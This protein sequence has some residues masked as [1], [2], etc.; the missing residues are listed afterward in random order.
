MAFKGESRNRGGIPGGRMVLTFIEGG[1]GI[2]QVEI[3]PKTYL[4]K[5]LFQKGLQESSGLTVRLKGLVSYSSDTF[6]C[7]FA[8]F[9]VSNSTF[10]CLVIRYGDQQGQIYFDD[11]ILCAVRLKSMFG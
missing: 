7:V 6:L 5:R 11:F 2:C 8:G 9:R 1:H 10:S 4:D 3:P